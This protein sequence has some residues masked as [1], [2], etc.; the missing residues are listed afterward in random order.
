MNL[1]TAHLRD[2]RG[3]LTLEFTFCAATLFML[4]VGIVAGG[5]LFWTHNA[6]VEATRRGAR[7]A[8][9]QCN[10]NDGS[11]P[12]S[13]TADSR[14]QNVVVYGTDSPGGGATPLVTNL[15][16]TNVT[17]S[18]ATDP[19]APNPPYGVG[20]GSVTVSIT[21]YQY[22][23]SIPGVSRTITL[24]PYQTTLTGECAGYVPPDQ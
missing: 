23:F 20:K 12:N 22:N 21:N 19:N 11:C 7:Y 6:L 3:T 18:R 14:I 2:Q 4:L 9:L 15:T 5:N 10:P 8:S 13:G 16:T 17:I 1:C 24:P